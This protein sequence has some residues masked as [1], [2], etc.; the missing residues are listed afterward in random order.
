MKRLQRQ[1]RDLR[2]EL[3]EAERKEQEQSR[4]RKAAVSLM[5]SRVVGERAKCDVGGGG[6]SLGNKGGGKKK[7]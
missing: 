4:R 5:Q 6:S 3:Q 7:N 1:L 2:V